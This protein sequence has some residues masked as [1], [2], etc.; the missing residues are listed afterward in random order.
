M[1]SLFVVSPYGATLASRRYVFV[2]AEPVETLLHTDALP[3][4]DHGR[5][6]KYG[7]DLYNGANVT[8][9]H[10]LSE[11]CVCVYNSIQHKLAL[12]HM[13]GWLCI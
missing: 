13:D 8:C 7:Y 6:G 9:K 10:T 1:K 11:M 4:Y 3:T 12:L 2:L 5:P